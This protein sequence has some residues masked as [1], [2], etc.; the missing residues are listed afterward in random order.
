[1]YIGSPVLDVSLGQVDAIS[2]VLSDLATSGEMSDEDEEEEEGGDGGAGQGQGGS[3]RKGVSG[4]RKARAS[5]DAQATHAQFDHILPPEQHTEWV[6]CDSGICRKWR[7]VAWYVDV[8]SLPDSW[9]CSM[10]HWDPENATC[11]GT[12]SVLT[13]Y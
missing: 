12:S 5:L 4:G 3:R 6:Q 8:S 9:Q 2:R 13:Q 10:N 11:E 1:M 7:R